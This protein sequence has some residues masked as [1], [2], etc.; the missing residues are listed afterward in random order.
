MF[1]ALPLLVMGFF[2]SGIVALHYLGSARLGRARLFGSFYFL[3]GLVGSSTVMMNPGDSET[4]L[5]LA[6]FA[7]WFLTSLVG[8][9]ILWSSKG[10]AVP[11]EFATALMA[12][13]G[14][15]ALLSAFTAQWLAADYSIHAEGEPLKN[16]T[17]VIERPNLTNVS[18]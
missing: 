12:L 13:M 17:V 4:P 18:G 5:L 9:A 15:S 3:T 14:T 7:L 10:L 16:A 11:R 1:W 6:V 8:F 2:A